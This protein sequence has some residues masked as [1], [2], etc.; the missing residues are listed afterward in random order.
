MGDFNDISKPSEKFGGRP[1]N[2]GKI[3]NFNNFLNTCGLLDLG[4]MGT[5]FTWTNGMTN[6]QVIR[7]RI[8]KCH[9]T[10]NWLALFLE[11]KGQH[12]PRTRSD[13]NP[14]ILKTDFRQAIGLKPFR[15]ETMWLS[16]PDFWTL[17]RNTWNNGNSTLQDTIYTFAQKVAAWNKEVFGN[18]Y[19]QKKQLLARL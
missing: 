6:G 9:A 11:S 1:P 3:N 4:F 14:I 15:F 5:R 17:V 16:H 12:L 2:Q 18:I 7:T 8:D 13:H 10:A 19:K